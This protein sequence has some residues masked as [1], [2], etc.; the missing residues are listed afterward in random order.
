MQE[1]RCLLCGARLKAEAFLDACTGL[2]DVRLGVLEAICPYCQGGFEIR[3]AT[4]RL[5]LGF[6]NGDEFQVA[7]SL[8]FEGLTLEFS[9]TPPRLS[10]TSPAKA[11]S[12]VEAD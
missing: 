6:R 9:M 3:P 10:L 8:P 5:D 2:L 11:W 1:H 4:G 12:F 7:Q